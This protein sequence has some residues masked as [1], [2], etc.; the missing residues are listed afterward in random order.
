MLRQGKTNSKKIITTIIKQKGGDQV[1]G[2]KWTP[3]HLVVFIH[4]GIQVSLLI[5]HWK[6]HESQFISLSRKFC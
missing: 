3:S 2:S 5:V 6:Q 1:L 4:K